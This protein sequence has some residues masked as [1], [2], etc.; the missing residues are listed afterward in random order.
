M[1][2]YAEQLAALSHDHHYLFIS[3]PAFLKRLDYRLTPP[4]V[5]MI[6]VRRRQAALGRDA[7]HTANWFNC[8][9]DEIYGSTESGVI[10]CRQRLQDN[11]PWQPFPCIRFQPQGNTIRLFSPLIADDNGPVIDDIFAFQ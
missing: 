3:S 4:P 5:A 2:E 7:M 8:W 11:A 6:F 1:I 9:P 10:A